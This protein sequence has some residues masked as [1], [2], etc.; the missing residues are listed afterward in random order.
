MTD[1]PYRQTI[2]IH[3]RQETLFRYFTEPEAIV[4]WMGDEAEVDPQPGGL[5]SSP[6]Q[7]SPE[8]PF[9]SSPV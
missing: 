6:D 1:E 7:Y 9:E 2:L 3:A 5:L 4:A 8:V